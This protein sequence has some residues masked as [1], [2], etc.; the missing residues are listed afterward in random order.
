[1]GMCVAPPKIMHFSSAELSENRNFKTP[2]FQKTSAFGIQLQDFVQ[3]ETQ[4][5]KEILEELPLAS[6]AA[7]MFRGPLRECA[8]M[9]EYYSD[10]VH[11]VGRKHHSMR[12]LRSRLFSGVAVTEES[13]RA[14]AK[15]LNAEL[16]ELYRGMS[17]KELKED[18]RD[19]GIKIDNCD[20]PTTVSVQQRLQESDA[21]WVTQA[22]V[23]ATDPQTNETNDA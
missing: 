5:V 12:T 15:L 13:A 6:A 1:M 17:L 18:L 11:C 21:L 8:G 22:K 14:C 23:T 2:D 7:V 9:E 19:R 10:E 16:A 4:D 3:T 20:V